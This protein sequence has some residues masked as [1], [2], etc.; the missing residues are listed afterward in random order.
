MST[1]A[2]TVETCKETLE[3][4]L[5]LLPHEYHGTRTQ[6]VWERGY[7]TGML[8]RMMLEDARLRIDL[9]RKAEYLTLRSK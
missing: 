9:E 6:I 3:K 5:E 7:L 1:K 4:I 2:V 8:A